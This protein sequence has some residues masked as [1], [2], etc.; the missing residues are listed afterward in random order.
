M[1]L[2]LAGGL[3]PFRHNRGFY[4]EGLAWLDEALAHG[5]DAPTLARAKALLAKASL[6]AVWGDGQPI[7]SLVEE[8]L[9]L[10]KEADNRLGVAWSLEVLATCTPFLAGEE[11]IESL[12]RQALH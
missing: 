8:S 12:A 6:L 7:L 10:F 11:H 5:R 9:R 1:A 2:R 3:R 4:N